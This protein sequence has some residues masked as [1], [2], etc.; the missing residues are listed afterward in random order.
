MSVEAALE[1]AEELCEAAQT[2]QSCTHPRPLRALLHLPDQYKLPRFAERRHGALVALVRSPMASAK[3]LTSE[4]Y[5]EHLSLEMRMQVLRTVHAM[6]D[7]PLH[8]W[9]VRRQGG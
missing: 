7:E 3:F 8:L 6:A 1:V 2:C 4:F 9:P 5:S